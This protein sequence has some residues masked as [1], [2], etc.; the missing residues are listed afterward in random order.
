MVACITTLFVHVREV[1]HNPR[2][3]RG[4]CNYTAELNS[5]GEFLGAF[6]VPTFDHGAHL[7]TRENWIDSTVLQYGLI[8]HRT[9]P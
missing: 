9:Q 8:L 1:P 5:F 2:G 6:G 7:K 3:S 4:A